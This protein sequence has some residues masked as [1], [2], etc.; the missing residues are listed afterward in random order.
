MKILLIVL[1]LFAAKSLS[2]AQLAKIEAEDVDYDGKRVMMTGKVHIDHQF[3]EIFCEEAELLMP[4]GETKKMTP[5]KIF[6]RGAV[7]V[8]LHDGSV[9]TSDAADIDCK[10]LEGYFTAEPPQKVTYLTLIVEEDKS[11]PVK[12]MS[13]AMRVSMKKTEGPKS[14]YVIRDVQAE[15]AVNIEYQNAL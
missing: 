6:L 7:K 3:G 12:A 9:L 2:G 8:R 13:R 15:G 4:A 1:L 11:I 10:T 5:E 14:E